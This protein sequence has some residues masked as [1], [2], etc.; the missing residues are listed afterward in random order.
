MAGAP[1]AL[2]ENAGA[3][4]HPVRSYQHPS[5]LGRRSRLSRRRRAEIELQH[6]TA[7][8]EITRSGFVRQSIEGWAPPMSL[9]H[10][11]AR[12]RPL[13]RSPLGSG[14]AD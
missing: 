6:R 4:E 7:S 12:C 3:A 11:F 2:I 9:Q 10:E 8:A 14:G 13:R 1:G 5:L